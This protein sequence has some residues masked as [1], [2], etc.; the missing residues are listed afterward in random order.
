VNTG[1]L[2][3]RYWRCG[4]QVLAVIFA[5]VLVY[6][7]FR[8]ESPPDFFY[9]SD[10]FIHLGAFTL[11]GVLMAAAFSPWF[12]PIMWVAG[13]LVSMGLEVLQ[14]I[15]QPSREF[16]LLDM[17]ANGGGIALAWGLVALVGFWGVRAGTPALGSD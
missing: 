11:F 5:A 13:I 17:A 8:P 10:K 16:S 12:T 15:L 3:Q 2:W 14:P 1:V 4:F 6:L 9:Y 7:L